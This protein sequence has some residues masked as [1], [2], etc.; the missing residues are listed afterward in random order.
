MDI[1]D[2][3]DVIPGLKAFLLERK[4]GPPLPPEGW[5]EISIGVE[6]KIALH[7]RGVTVR[8]ILNALSEA[9][10]AYPA[11]WQPKGWL[12]TI[13]PDSSFVRG[14]KY[15]F[16]ALVGVSDVWRQEAKSRQGE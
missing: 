12:V 16:H 1:N 9:E 3:E 10:E 11:R 8:Q 4:A 13:Q 14:G 7:L 2:S 6:P 15:S 5:S